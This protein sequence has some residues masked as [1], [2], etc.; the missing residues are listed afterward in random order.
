MSRIESACF[1]NVSAVT[2]RDLL[3]F[4]MLVRMFARSALRSCIAA[5]SSA[6]LR[7]SQ[8]VSQRHVA[9]HDMS[10]EG[11]PGLEIE[12]VP[13]PEQVTSA[14]SVTRFRVLPGQSSGGYGHSCV[15]HARTSVKSPKFCIAHVNPPPPGAGLLHDLERVCVPG[16]KPPAPKGQEDVHSVHAPQSEG[17]P[18]V[19]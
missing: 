12:H 19:T 18:F 14:C 1:F 5:S 8:P 6:H 11:Q 10:F 16:K 7:P 4:T 3:A 15:L 9:R 17:P 2:S 13:C